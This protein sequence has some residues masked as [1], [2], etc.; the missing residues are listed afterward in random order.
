MAGASR[1]GRK[2][3]KANIFIYL[4][5]I[6]GSVIMI[7][8]FLWMILTSFKSVPETTL[9]PPTFFPE[10]FQPRG[11]CS[12]IFVH[13]GIRLCKGTFSHEESVLCAGGITAYVPGAGVYST[14]V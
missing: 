13:G 6:L 2:I 12:R 14:P 7:F 8:P 5:L 10:S 3:S 4:V 9:V 11:L 1:N